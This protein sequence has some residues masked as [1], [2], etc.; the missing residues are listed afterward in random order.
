MLTAKFIISSQ[1]PALPGHFPGSPI[2]PGIV[3]LDHIARG[4]LEQLP[5]TSLEGFPQVKFIQPLL[6]DVEVLV[7]YLVKTESLYQFSAKVGEQKILSGQMR[8]MGAES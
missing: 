1:H 6:P 5:G 8:V 3:S 2:T 4:L 7:T